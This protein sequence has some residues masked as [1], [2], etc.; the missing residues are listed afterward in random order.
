MTI[1]VSAVLSCADRHGF[2]VDAVN[3]IVASIRERWPELTDEQMAQVLDGL[4]LQP[5]GPVWFE[6]EPTPSA[7]PPR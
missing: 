1:L 5:Q 2:P 6:R 3:D 7:P 4:N